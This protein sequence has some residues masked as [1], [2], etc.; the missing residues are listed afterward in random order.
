MA[1][2]DL[3][4]NSNLDPT[5]SRSVLTTVIALA[6]ATGLAACAT[7]TTPGASDPGGDVPANPTDVVG[8]GMV[9]QAGDKA[10][11]LCLGAIM[12]SYPPQC[13][14]VELTGWEW[15]ADDGSENSGDVTWGSYAVWGVYDGDSLAVS[16]S[17]MLA[18]YDPMFVQDPALLPENKGASTDA[19]LNAV[20]DTI[21]GD[22]P[23]EILGSYP[24]NGYLF[25]RVVFDDGTYQEWADNR[26]GPDVVQVRSVLSEIEG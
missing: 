5:K 18:L 8:A 21:W 13:S 1:L 9:L 17:V 10:P 6:L 16:D 15:A 20:S 11:E 7:P 4:V 25:V 24:E 14:G 23:F 2:E 22:A 26:Y 12:E 3:R 19:E